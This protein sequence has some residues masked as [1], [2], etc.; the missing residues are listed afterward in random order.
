M[1]VGVHFGK[2]LVRFGK[3][4]VWDCWFILGKGLVWEWTPSFGKG[5]VCFW[6]GR[7]GNRPLRFWEGLEQ[8]AGTNPASAR[9]VLVRGGR[10]RI[11]EWN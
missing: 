5:L 6:E 4:L 7:F 11:S 3:G 8:D 2:G 9:P 1:A 10:C